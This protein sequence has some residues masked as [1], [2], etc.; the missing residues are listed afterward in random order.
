[1]SSIYK[2]PHRRV[3]EPTE[4]D[5]IRGYAH[6]AAG[7]GRKETLGVLAALLASRILGKAMR[8]GK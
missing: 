6:G 4:A 7:N 1:M 2:D 3:S 8:R 5:F